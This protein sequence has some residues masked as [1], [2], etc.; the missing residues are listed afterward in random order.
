MTYFEDEPGPPITLVLFS[1]TLVPIIKYNNIYYSING[2]K[3]SKYINRKKIYRISIYHFLTLSISLNNSDDNRSVLMG[4]G[5]KRIISHK[6]KFQ[7][8]IY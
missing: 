7:E 1:I 3:N 6:S 4:G 5:N 8:I 2:N